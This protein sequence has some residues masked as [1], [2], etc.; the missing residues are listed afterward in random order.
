MRTTGLLLVIA[1]TVATA[2]ELHEAARICFADR[3]RE[4]LSQNPSVN[5]VDEDGR[6]PLHVAVDGQQIACVGLLLEAGAD[7]EV[8]DEKGRTAYGAAD[9]LVDRRAR[10]TIRQYLDAKSGPKSSQT[11]MGPTPWSLEYAVLRRQTAVTKMLLEMGADPNKAGTNGTTPLADAALKGDLAAVRLLLDAGA[12]ASCLENAL[13]T[14]V[15]HRA[16]HVVHGTQRKETMG[17]PCAD[18]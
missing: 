10:A 4:L 7:R 17:H 9:Q 1:S 13:G 11:P 6:T 12:R 15:A 5:Q 14:W 2:G 3:M 18:Q 8:R 16:V